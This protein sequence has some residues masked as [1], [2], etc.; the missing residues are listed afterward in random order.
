MLRVIGFYATEAIV[1]NE[2]IE[3]VDTSWIAIQEKDLRTIVRVLRLT[4]TR[5]LPFID[6]EDTV[7]GIDSRCQGDWPNLKYDF[8]TSFVR[9]WRLLIGDFLGAGPTR[10]E[11][12]DLRTSW[13]KT[14]AWCKELSQNNRSVFAFT[15]QPQLD[16]YSWMFASNGKLERQVVFEDGKFLT[17]FGTETEIE[18]RL[19]KRFKLDDVGEKWVPDVGTVAR[20]ARAW[21]V[22]PNRSQTRLRMGWICD[23]DHKRRANNEIT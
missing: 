8:V 20:I 3:I 2:S 13:K 15:D 10:K 23:T 14:A 16:W 4:P 21:S 11:P 5:E 1:L 12:G 18:S 22:D 7:F 19:R 9:G 6:A 17:C